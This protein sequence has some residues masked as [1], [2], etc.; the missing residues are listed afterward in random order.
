MTRNNKSIAAGIG[1][2]VGAILLVGTMASP[3]S[4]RWGD[5]NE[6][7][8]ERHGWNG[9]YYRPPP[10]VYGGYGDRY[11]YYPPPVVYGRPGFGIQLPGVNLNIR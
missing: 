11:G 9:N 2:V 3:A 8:G 7:W 10:V 1:A 5:H 4:A 6:R